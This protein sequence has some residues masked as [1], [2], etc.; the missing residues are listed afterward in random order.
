MKQLVVRTLSLLV[1]S[2]GNG[3]V[4]DTTSSSEVTNGMII[5]AVDI[6]GSPLKGCSV[7][8]IDQTHWYELT[9]KGQT[10]VTET[11]MTGENGSVIFDSLRS[12]TYSIVVTGASIGGRKIITVG[13]RSTLSD[14][15][16]L[17]DLS[18]I[19][20][21]INSFNGTPK[22]VRIVGTEITAAC[23]NEGKFTLTE[24]PGDS[25][26]IV[27]VVSTDSRSVLA[28]GKGIAGTGSIE[29]GEIQVE[30]DAVILDDFNDGD[31]YS[32]FGWFTGH[33]LWYAYDDSWL[34]GNSTMIP[35]SALANPAMAITEVDAWQGKSMNIGFVM[36]NRISSPHASF[37]CQL[38]EQADQYAN[39]SGLRQLTCRGVP[40]DR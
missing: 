25:S 30:P 32:I 24:V 36:G 13:D 21:T 2:C 22:S 9:A 31:Q 28:F 10:A 33:G 6:D 40:R 4:A 18:A 11:G 39:L 16:R 26:E 29:T 38:R 5:T 20:G 3:S 37:A 34:G 14:T 15:I 27:A 8:V 1:L 17:A 12:G 7:S 35:A 23:D 19:S